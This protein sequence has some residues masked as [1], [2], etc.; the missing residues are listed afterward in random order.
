MSRD[1]LIE[2]CK[3][4]HAQ[5]EDFENLLE[6]LRS[7]GASKVDSIA[8]IVSACDVDLRRAKELVHFSSAWR[9]RREADETF[10]ASFIETLRDD[11]SRS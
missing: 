4:R 3:A 2:K 11:S 7:A 1:E 8:V 10:H 5:G 9:D 6:F